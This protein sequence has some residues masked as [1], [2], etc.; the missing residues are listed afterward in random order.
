MSLLPRRADNLIYKAIRLAVRMNYFVLF[1][2][3]Y[4][5][6]L[7]P[8]PAPLEHTEIESSRVTFPIWSIK[9]GVVAGE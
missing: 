1:M 7:P 3:Y 9:D 4:L 6:I 2:Q 5:R 8:A